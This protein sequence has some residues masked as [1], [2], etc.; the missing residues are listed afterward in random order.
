[1]RIFLLLHLLLM[2]VGCNSEYAQLSPI[3]KTRIYVKPTLPAAITASKIMLWGKSSSGAAFARFLTQDQITSYILPSGNY[4]LYTIA[5][6]GANLSGD[7]Y[8]STDAGILAGP[9]LP[10]DIA[11]T[12]D[13]CDIPD[14]R[15]LALSGT[16]PKTLGNVQV[17]F[18]EALTGINGI[19]DECSDDLTLGP[20][21][22][23]RGHA[24]SYRYVLST[25]DKNGASYAVKS[26]NIK[27]A[28][29]KGTPNALT[30]LK[31]IAESET[32][33]IPAGDGST[34]PFYLTVETF[35][36]TLNCD[37]NLMNPV[38][39]Q[40]GLRSNTTKVKHLTIAST[41][42]KLYVQM[43]SEEV[44]TAF[45][46][47]KP[48]AGGD[49]SKEAPYLICNETQFY[50]THT[51]ITSSFKLMS[52][53]D[54][55]KYYYGI[56]P[57]PNVPD[58]LT[59]LA[60][61]SNFYPLGY[62]SSCTATAETFTTSDFDGGGKTIKG[63]RIHMPTKDFVGLYI[64]K[65]GGEI[66]RLN[67]LN[68]SIQGQSNVGG[69]AGITETTIRDINAE[70]L[71]V[72][73]STSVGALAGKNDNGPSTACEFR[74]IIL[75][76]IIISAGSSNIGG[77]I[78][79][80]HSCDFYS[81]SVNGYVFSGSNA[82]GGITGYITNGTMDGVS[83]DG[84]VAG[85]THV[86]GLAGD[87]FN[88]IIKNSYA[89]GSILASHAGP[90]V[91]AGGLIGFTNG[92][93]SASASVTD[94]YFYGQINHYCTAMPD[95]GCAISNIVGDPGSWGPGDFTSN[96]YISTNATLSKSVFDAGTSRTVAQFFSTI[97]SWSPSFIP[98]NTD[99]PR[100]THEVTS[101]PC[102]TVPFATESVANQILNG[103][104]TT[105]N[106]ISLCNFSQIKDMQAAPA[107]TS[108]AYKFLS[109][110]LATEELDPSSATFFG[111]LEGDLKGI[112]RLTL[113]GGSGTNIAWWN[114]LA[115]TAKMNSLYFI[116]ARIIDSVNAAATTAV[117]ATTNNG[118]LNAVHTMSTRSNP[119]PA[120]THS[121]YVHT[122]AGS[123][124]ILNSYFNGSAV[125]R[126][127]VATLN[128]I[129]QGTIADSWTTSYLACNPGFVCNN[130][131]G[132]VIENSGT[133]R[134]LDLTTTIVE[135]IVIAGS[136]DLYFIAK[137]NTGTI[138]DVHIKQTS[139]IDS[140]NKTAHSIGENRANGIV[141]RI[142]N[143]GKILVLSAD[144][145]PT[146]PVTTA[147]YLFGATNTV[148]FNLG[149][150]SELAYKYIPRWS[151]QSQYGHV[152]RTPSGANEC[153]FVG[154]GGMPAHWET[155]MMDPSLIGRFGIMLGDN[156]STFL[157]T[158][159]PTF[160]AGNDTFYFY[161][162]APCSLVL[163]N[164]TI[165]FVP[166]DQLNGAGLITQAQSQMFSTFSTW[167]GVL[168]VTGNDSLIHQYNYNKIL[169]LNPTKPVWYFDTTSSLRL[170]R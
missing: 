76:K 42:H 130:I 167:D 10:I 143:E 80:S 153:E 81:S 142:Y 45:A 150:V 68:T 1:M 109:F 116:D 38:V 67:L 92:S 88:A 30:P 54:L 95:D 22:E 65:L 134:G 43:S 157:M 83:F 66:R 158:Q 18:C 33:Q 56:T 162:P 105:A 50:N 35:P 100:L 61:G 17:E 98:S 168:D 58:G 82:V 57:L 37:S 60:K 99:L 24:M 124:K 41:A 111:Q 49:G 104:G 11:L 28:C 29:L 170:N 44:C 48:F 62:N 144:L 103:R 165:Y 39:L 137:K 5:W 31:G 85:L 132:V 77:I 148:G 129:N 53:I 128:Y 51:S 84:Y 123:G 8:C 159:T 166:F 9:D 118:E 156:G 164:P 141:Q 13:K 55:T 139:R 70:S 63:L 131:S 12:N 154:S 126:Q 36:D 125:V 117:I 2:L 155:P 21:Q 4:T 52:D 152:S 91:Y 138:E 110:I 7:V 87:L 160:T 89:T 151:F 59:C 101:H 94:N 73:A 79:Q 90:G 115:S 6:T 107:H 47:T 147:D 106:P 14:F 96:Y 71:T 3:R 102:R 146:N 122:N 119:G 149:Q 97:T 16:V 78:G 64:K 169:G 161:D 40:N 127:N 108:K 114:A 136:S 135:T 121:M 93:P 120:G 133:I 145:P 32:T 69:L 113:R 75:N 163:A 27:S 19:S 72:V 20:R 23:A 15:G 74:N 26:E 86:G 46:K 112:V 140:R 34:T 25:F